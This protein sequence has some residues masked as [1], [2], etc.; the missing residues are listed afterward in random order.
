ML[1]KSEFNPQCITPSQVNLIYNI[2]IFLRRLLTWTRAYII[3]SY[4]G[5]GSA[6]ELFGRL[7][8]ES[9]DFANLILAFFG[10]RNSNRYTQLLNQFVYTLRDLITAQLAGN[11]NAVNENVNRL[12]Q[13]MSDRAAF[14]AS[15]NPYF[16]ETEWKNMLNSYLQ[17]I[18]EEA[19]AF[20]S[21]DYNKD[22]ELFDQLNSLTNKMGDY[23]AQTLFDYITSGL[24]TTNNPPSQGGQQCITYE[25]LNEIFTIRTM[26]FNLAIWI[27]NF[28]LSKFRGIGDVNAVFNR[29]QQIPA[30][31]INALK[32]VFGDNPVLDD[33]LLQLNTFIDLVDS[34][35]TAQMEGKT[36]E[37]QRITQLLYQ[38]ANDRAASLSALNPSYW[39]QNELRTV[40]SD[41]VS[42]MIAEST[43]FL[44]GNYARELDIFSTI[45]DEADTVSEYISQGLISY[46]T[47][48]PK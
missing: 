6:E 24:Q 15:I 38:N 32:Q 43:S 45:L 46:I 37:L 27:R 25:Q 14:L 4:T 21:G 39:N 31:F 22:I 29:L 11:T 30:E 41:T 9:S 3:S 17:Y 40:L 28:M 13:N 5:A 10:R 8:L 12:Y 20:S 34:F 19:N 16:S 26:W 18:L 36:D 48:R 1:L 44:T 42:N 33:Y 35:T 47:S 2:R 7:T 23:F